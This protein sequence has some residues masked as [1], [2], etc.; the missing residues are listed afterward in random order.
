MKTII[1]MLLLVVS[2]TLY[3]Q[4]PARFSKDYLLNP[5]DS[6]F[7][8]QASNCLAL[9]NSDEYITPSIYGTKDSAFYLIQNINNSGNLLS[10]KKY[11]DT[12]M[13]NVESRNIKK[14]NN[15]YLIIGNVGYYSKYNHVQNKDAVIVKVKPNGDTVFVKIY[16]STIYSIF[17]DFVENA[18]GGFTLVGMAQ[19]G[20]A[21]GSLRKDIIIRTDS[22]GNELWRK[23]YNIPLHYSAALKILPTAD[24]CYLV[25]SYDQVQG[26]PI[27]SIVVYKLDSLGD[28][29]WKHIYPSSNSENAT[30]LLPTNDGNFL[31]V[32][33]TLIANKG[34]GLLL[35]IDTSGTVLWKKTYTSTYNDINFTDATLAL[36]GDLLIAGTEDTTYYDTNGAQQRIAEQFIIRLS[37]D[38]Q[39][40]V[41]LKRYPT[42]SADSAAHS[43]RGF[44]KIYA[45]PDNGAIALGSYGK[46]NFVN[47]SHYYIWLHK[48]DSLGCADSA[49]CVSTVGVR[50]VSN[51]QPQSGSVISV[52]PNPFAYTAQVQVYT[53]SAVATLQLTNTLGIVVHTYILQEGDNTIT[54]YKNNMSAGMYYCTLR[55][56]GKIVQ[57]QKIVVSE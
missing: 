20:L 44:Y 50:E 23:I 51:I 57:V 48:M 41:W 11:F 16:K 55:E 3:A 1:T 31:I 29:L 4:I 36:N 17:Y 9:L 12:L 52:S 42:S 37:Q 33:G 40:T 13:L 28:M 46:Q 35:K 47:T 54:L 30:N 49:G 14:T 53:S 56:Q 15:N 27:G 7:Q 21:P 18:D 6:F 24:S 10:T 22:L 38:G 5:N 32:G 8:V 26:S 39:D 19:V 45:T 25:L 34:R 2:I 43:G